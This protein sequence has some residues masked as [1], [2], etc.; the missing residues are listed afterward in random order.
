VLGDRHYL[1]SPGSNVLLISL[2]FLVVKD[3]YL[4]DH[5]YNRCILSV[6]PYPLAYYNRIYQ[7]QVHLLVALLILVVDLDPYFHRFLAIDWYQ[8]ILYDN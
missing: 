4:S 7:L 6:V 8:F 2:S 5:T 1:G 3:A